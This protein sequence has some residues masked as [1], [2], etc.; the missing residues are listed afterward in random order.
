MESGRF[1]VSMHFKWQ[2]CGFFF[3]LLWSAGSA[4]KYPPPEHK[5]ELNYWIQ[6][7]IASITTLT[8]V[9]APIEIW[10][11]N[12]WW[13]FSGRR[14][15]WL[16]QDSQYCFQEKCLYKRWWSIRYHKRKHYERPL[17]STNQDTSFHYTYQAWFSIK[18]SFIV[19][20]LYSPIRMGYVVFFSF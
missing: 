8:K 10:F 9:L 3:A 18:L 11:D 19:H 5:Y 6:S 7:H 13:K 16:A 17:F 14:D 20:Y 12:L 2:W 15:P 4:W 1:V